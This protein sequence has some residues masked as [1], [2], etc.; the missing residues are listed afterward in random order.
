V[1]PA[2]LRPEA[3]SFITALERRSQTRWQV[4]REEA[5]SWATPLIVEHQAEVQVIAIESA[6]TIWPPGNSV[7]PSP[8]AA[9]GFVY[10]MSNMN[11]SRGGLACALPLDVTGE[12]TGGRLLWRY[13]RGIPHVASPLL[14]KN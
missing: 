13:E 6:A 12:I 3:D 5:S 4:K 1:H 8:V 14:L 2:Q 10:Y 7:I 9:V 11:G